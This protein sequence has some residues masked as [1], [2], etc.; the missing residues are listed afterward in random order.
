MFHNVLVAIT[1]ILRYL[2]QIARIQSHHFGDLSYILGILW[3]T[4]YVSRKSPSEITLFYSC[5]FKISNTSFTRDKIT[6]SLYTPSNN[7]INYPFV[8]YLDSSSLMHR[9][10]DNN[11]SF[12]IVLSSNISLALCKL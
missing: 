6:L 3:R 7:I 4:S 11:A 2:L 8:S 5:T 9:K 10:H 12:M 1:L